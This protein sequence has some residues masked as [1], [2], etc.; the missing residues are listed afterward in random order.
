MTLNAICHD[1]I[2]AI[3]SNKSSDACIQITSCK[4]Q[5]PGFIFRCMARGLT[6]PAN[7]CHKMTSYGSKFAYLQNQTSVCKIP[8]SPNPYRDRFPLHHFLKPFFFLRCSITII[9]TIICQA[10][11]SLSGGKR[12]ADLP[13]KALIS[14]LVTLNCTRQKVLPSQR[15]LG[16]DR[17][18]IGHVIQTACYKNKQQTSLSPW[19][20]QLFCF[21]ESRNLYH[22]E[23]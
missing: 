21:K 6:H 22:N 23:K 4:T 17:C 19:N 9:V 16:G 7:Q 1:R 3:N 2:D 20:L 14:T 12:L 18:C 8:F 10:P 13:P 15:G 5:P 11:S